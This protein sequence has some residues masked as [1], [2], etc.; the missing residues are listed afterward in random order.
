MG[1][2]IAFRSRDGTPAVDVESRR[3]WPKSL[4]AALEANDCRRADEILAG[5]KILGFHCT[6]LLSHE[7]A[8]ILD[9][10]LQPLSPEL[11]EK[12]VQSARRL[13]HL[14]Q[15]VADRLLRVNAAGD[16]YRRGM[17]WFVFRRSLLRRKSGV[18]SLLCC[19][20]GEAIY[21]LHT[22]DP[23]VGPVLKTIG[24]PSL[25]VAAVPGDRIET[26]RLSRF[27]LKAD[28]AA[29]GDYVKGPISAAWIIDIV[30]R[31]DP[32]FEALTKYSTWT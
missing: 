23:D 17:I 32:R 11:A 18:W 27:F 25:V 8:E 15:T 20:G 12:R 7:R 31:S 13:N 10:G 1:R 3:T 29:S 19:W 21:G 26:G 16:A 28:G 4:R 9:G 14:S 30:D 22:G 24:E 2:S 6:K 5:E